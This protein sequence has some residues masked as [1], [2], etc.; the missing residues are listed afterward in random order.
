LVLELSSDSVAVLL[1]VNR[2]PTE[3]Y[4]EYTGEETPFCTGVGGSSEVCV[5]VLVKEAQVVAGS[6]KRGVDVLKSSRKPEP[7]LMMSRSCSGFV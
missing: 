6:M 5:E 3:E 2:F 7:S 1:R 4:T